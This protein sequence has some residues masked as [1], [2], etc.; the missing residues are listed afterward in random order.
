MKTATPEVRFIAIKAYR[1]GISRQQVADIVGYHLK[2]VSR[3]ILE[4][5]RENRLEA[6]ERGHRPS[7]FSDAECHELVEL[8]KKQVDITLS[9][10]R[11]YFAKDCSLNAIHKLLK[12]LGFVYKKNSK[13]KRTGTRRHRSSQACMERVPK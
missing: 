11:S 10:I 9:E 3:W 2:S 5:E 12:K 8:V 6:R 1:S 7:M 13:S 4:Y